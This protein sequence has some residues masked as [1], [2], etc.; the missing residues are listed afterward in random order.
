MTEETQDIREIVVAGGCFWGVEA[1]YQQL[2]GIVATEEGYAQG[3]VDHPTYEAVC[4]ME[5]D[6]AEVVKIIYDANVIA[7]EKILEHLFRMIDPLSLNQQGNDIGTQYR[8]G[9]YYSDKTDLPIIKQFISKEQQAYSAPI[10]VEVEPLK[11]FWPAEDF[12]Q[13]YLLKNPQG[14]CHINFA[15][16]K[17]SER[18]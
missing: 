15:L 18:K 6:H 13:D 16:I 5:T 11:T 10:A 8:S 3:V 14:Y 1:Y 7:L 4:T 17:P 2:K 9:I 12:H